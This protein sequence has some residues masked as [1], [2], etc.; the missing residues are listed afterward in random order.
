MKNKKVLLLSFL[1]GVMIATAVS[2]SAA[3]VKQK[4]EAYKSADAVITLD[5][6]KISMPS[7]Y[8]VLFYNDR[9][10]TPV[11]TV[12]EALGAT[13]TWD[14][15]NQTVKIVSGPTETASPSTTTPS[16]SYYGDGYF[17]QGLPLKSVKDGITV[18]VFGSY[19]YND[20][21]LRLVYEIKNNRDYDIYPKYDSIYVKIDNSET[22]SYD[23]PLLSQV[24]VAVGATYE[25]N[26]DIEGYEKDDAK[27]KLVIPIV[28]YS[29]E[30]G[31]AVEKNAE[32]TFYI[33]L[34]ETLK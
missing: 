26:F 21:V 4:V 30:A 25:L 22:K 14:E 5:G 1:A 28:Y 2:V 10:Y 15:A 24:P 19:I 11:R 9:T 3:G 33:N 16:A 27:I 31:K 13:V 34:A 17:Y 6:K 12:A 20:N 18:N 8:S 23:L 7:D 29:M 32:F